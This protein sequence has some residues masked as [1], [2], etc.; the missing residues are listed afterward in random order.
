MTDRLLKIKDVCHLAAPGR[1]RSKYN[2]L[3]PAYWQTHT[4]FCQRARFR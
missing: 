4:A 3:A 1:V 2:Y